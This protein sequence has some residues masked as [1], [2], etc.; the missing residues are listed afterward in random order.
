MSKDEVTTFEHATLKVGHYSYGGMSSLFFLN[1]YSWQVP[2]ELLN[3]K[4]RSGQ[5]VM[6]RE[7]SQVNAACSEGIAGVGD[8]E[9]SVN[10]VMGLLDAVDHKVSNMRKKVRSSCHKSIIS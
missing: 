3:R 4:F 5:K 10:D 7:S 1:M 8:A 2:Y 6:D 9:V